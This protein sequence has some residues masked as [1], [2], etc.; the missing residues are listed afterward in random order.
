MPSINL[1]LPQFKRRFASKKFDKLNTLLYLPDD[2]SISKGL[3]E[4][5]S[6][7]DYRVNNVL[8]SFFLTSS[9]E[10]LQKKAVECLIQKNGIKAIDFF[11]SILEKNPELIRKQ[12]ALDA[13]ECFSDNKKAKIALDKFKSISNVDTFITIKDYAKL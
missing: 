5:A 13:L 9:S 8:K 2:E 4:I 6:L 12:L 3:E 10:V 1:K 7:R 11:I